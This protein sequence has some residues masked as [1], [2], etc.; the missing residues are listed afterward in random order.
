MAN[1]MPGPGGAQAEPTLVDNT[2]VDRWG[3]ADLPTVELSAGDLAIVQANANQLPRV[4]AANPG[5]TRRDVRYQLGRA[6]WGAGS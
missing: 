5:V 4:L 6:P 1:G 3:Q 2:G